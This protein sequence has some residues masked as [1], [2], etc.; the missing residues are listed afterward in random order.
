MTIKYSYS[1]DFGTHNA[2][3]FSEDGVKRKLT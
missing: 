1:A 2:V 3:I